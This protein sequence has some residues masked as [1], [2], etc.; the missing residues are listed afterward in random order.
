MAMFWNILVRYRALLWSGVQITIVLSLITI[1]FGLLF[2]SLMALMKLCR[3]AP[4]RW[5]ANAYVEFIRGTPVLVQIFL[6]YY[7]L[8]LMGVQL[9]KIMM[10]DVDISRILSGSI[11]L[12]I[13]STAYICEIVRSGIQSIDRGQTE[14]ALALG[15]TPARTMRDIIFPQALRNIFPALCNEFI[16]VI[17]TSSQCSVIGIADLMYT[18][19]TIRGISF[20]PIEPLVIVAIL[21]FIITFTLSLV[22]KQ[23]EKRLRRRTA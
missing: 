16:T 18:A 6:V 21:Y 4:L 19:N 22:L 11:A 20:R 1:V 23:V 9:P 5:I 14:G 7:G 3:I 10:G 12:V 8:P 15:L 17:K 13:N 2:G